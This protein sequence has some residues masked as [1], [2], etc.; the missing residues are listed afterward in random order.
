MEGRPTPDFDAFYADAYPR[1]HRLALARTGSWAAAEDLAQDALADAHRR[2]DR[3]GTYD[4]PLAWARR[5][6]LNRSISRLRR[7]GRE[8]RAVQRLAGQA[9]VRTGEVPVFSDESLWT[10]IR[11][12]SPRQ[13]EVV[14]LLWFEDLP[15]AE[16]AAILD[17]GEETVRTHWRRARAYLA[18][19][20]GE[21]A[22]TEQSDDPTEEAR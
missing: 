17:C 19:A 13:L 9:D 16:V 5:A 6:V 8:Q 14:L 7:R 15:A 20:L 18:E 3:I 11:A 1:I 10:A 21:R 2:W 12:L 22:D 4:D